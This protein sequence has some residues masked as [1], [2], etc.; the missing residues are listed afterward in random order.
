MPDFK[1][2]YNQWLLIPRPKAPMNNNKSLSP[3][4]TAKKALSVIPPSPKKDK[5]TS[6]L[7]NFLTEPGIKAFLRSYRKHGVEIMD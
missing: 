4:R 7:E 5:Q 3:V 2:A 6:E 1:Q